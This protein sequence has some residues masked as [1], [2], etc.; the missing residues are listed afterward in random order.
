MADYLILRGWFR[1]EDAEKVQEAICSLRL[2]HHVILH[3]PR[4]LVLLGLDYTSTQSAE[5]LTSRLA[6]VIANRD[7]RVYVLDF[8]GL[9]PVS[10][11]YV[12]A[13]IAAGRLKEVFH[14]TPPFTEKVDKT[15]KT[16]EGENFLVASGKRKRY[17]TFN[18]EAME[19]M[20]G[21]ISLGEGVHLPVDDW[22]ADIVAMHRKYGHTVNQSPT[23]P[24]LADLNL[25]INLIE[26]EVNLEFIGSLRL[27]RNRI[28]AY[29]YHS[30]DYKSKLIPGAAEA[31]Q[32][33]I[34]ENTAEIADGA[35][36]SIVVILGLLACMGIDPKPLWREVRRA[37]MAKTPYDPELAAYWEQ[38]LGKSI[39]KGKFLKPKDWTPPDIK[40]VLFP[41]RPSDNENRNQFPETIAGPEEFPGEDYPMESA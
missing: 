24:S 28:M 38:K 26:E 18:I 34:E 32:E 21:T 40:G 36:D 39:P 16:K 30:P 20:Y 25:R 41:H 19:N 4:S 6:S 5:A 35:I 7:N 9:D 17:T 8:G 11:P 23:V 10:A 12:S 29:E 14:Y 27:L 15:I 37:N 3:T 2:S 33:R 22:F 1:V 13:A 31:N